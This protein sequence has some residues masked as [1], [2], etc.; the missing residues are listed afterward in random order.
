M[1]AA[2]CGRGTVHEGPQASH[3][4][5]AAASPS[6]AASGAWTPPAVP[7]P[8]TVLATYSAASL[9][10]K[11][12]SDL[13]VGPDGNLYVTDGTER[14][15][16][17]SPAGKV[18]R[19]FGGPGKGPGQFTF[20]TKDNRDPT[21][22]AASVAVG[23]DGDVYVADSG[24]ARIEV[25]SPTGDFLRQFGS[26][27]LGNGQFLLPFDLGVDAQ[28]DVYVVDELRDVVEKYS[29][30]GAFEWAV[31][32][33]T[34]STDPDLT[35]FVGG[36]SV[37]PHGTV[38]VTSDRP[39]AVSYLDAGGHKIDVVHTTGY[40]PVAGV[41]PCDATLDAAGDTFVQSCPGLYTVGE[42]A[43]PPYQYALVFDRTHHLIGAWYDSPF[44]S[45]SPRFGPNGEAFVM[46][47]Y[48]T[49]LKLK[50]SLP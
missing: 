7:N 3:A 37:D 16:V 40:Y 17:V 11:N 9:G 49:I 32:S 14:V 6:V 22:L 13:A 35:A 15:T 29:P 39:E 18:I 26:S 12:P 23:P 31:G 27:Y 50:I 47:D 1:V 19:R 2:G 34:G 38:V 41:G 25:F 36:A 5:S 30:T 33:G 8:F 42:A 45:R 28:G 24:N 46:G 44:D 43:K 4:A 21:D 10:L 48:G 20:Q